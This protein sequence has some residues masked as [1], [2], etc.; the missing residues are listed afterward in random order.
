MRLLILTA[1]A[2][3]GH[4]SLSFAVENYIKYNFP[5]D[6]VRVFD[7]YKDNH[8]LFAWIINDL[9]FWNLQHFPH[10]MRFQYR[11]SLEN[12][13]NKNHNGSVTFGCIA[14]KDVLR[15]IE[16]FKPDAILSTHTF[17]TGLLNY[18]QRK[19]KISKAIKLFTVIPDYSPHP[20]TET[21]LDFDYVF[22][23]CKEIHPLLINTKDFKEE[24]LIP[25][26]LPVHNKFY[27]AVNKEE[28]AKEVNIDINKFTLLVFSG[29]MSVGNNYKITKTLLKSKCFN[30][31]N[32][33]VLNGKNKK[34]KN[35]IDKLIKK[36]NLTNIYNY[37]FTKDVHKFM[38]ISSCMIGKLGA[39]TTNECLIKYLP[40]IVPFKPPYHEYW[41]MKFLEKEGVIHVI[42]GYK[43]LPDGLENLVNNKDI[44]ENIKKNM[45]HLRKPNACKDMVNL[46]KEVTNGKTSS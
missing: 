33:I 2:G 20:D 9:H 17:A 19:N 18:L 14:K 42:D 30:D 31:I 39:L 11:L 38:S 27:D 44:L 10:L 41:N 34:T 36:Q 7:L 43:N 29:G 21:N 16:E 22:T 46:I 24:Q 37:G 45:E 12:K 3:E 26:G 28:F 25:N 4:N 15:Q 8:K 6:E 23:P 32:V 40:I 13:A 35:K 5:N 1:T